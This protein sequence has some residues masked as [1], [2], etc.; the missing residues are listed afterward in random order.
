MRHDTTKKSI[1]I[2]LRTQQESNNG[3]EGD[4]DSYLF[5]FACTAISMP[6]LNISNSYEYR[7]NLFR[8]VCADFSPVFYVIVHKNRSSDIFKSKMGSREMKKYCRILS[9]T[10]NYGTTD[11]NVKMFKYSKLYL[12][13]FIIINHDLKKKHNWI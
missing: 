6:H 11:K 1:S 10:N 2:C 7:S 8:S 5:V 13:C 9:C 3:T 4:S 12:F